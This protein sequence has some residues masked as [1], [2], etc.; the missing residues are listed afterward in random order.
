MMPIAQLAISGYGSLI[1]REVARATTRETLELNIPA[2]LAKR[3]FCLLRNSMI[4]VAGC[5]LSFAIYHLISKDSESI[6]S[7][8][9]YSLVIMARVYMT[10]AFAYFLGLRQ[11]GIDKLVML[12]CSVSSLIFVY[13]SANVFSGLIYIVI[14]YAL[15]N[16]FCT[17]IVA[18]LFKKIKIVESNKILPTNTI[19]TKEIFKM[20]AINF[21]GFLTLNTD[22]YIAKAYL[23]KI[24][25]LEF[26]IV[27][28]AMLGFIS[29]SSI[30][31]AIQTS[32]YA[33][34]Y[35]MKNIED[36]IKQVKLTASIISTFVIAAGFIFIV[37]YDILVREIISQQH[38][39]SILFLA[40]WLIFVLVVVNIM[41]IGLAIISIGDSDLVKVA[42]PVAVL[43]L[44]GAVIGAS[45]QGAIGMI[46]AMTL[47][48]MLSLAMHI[49]LFRKILNK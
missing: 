36:L 35:A 11:Y 47:C 2:P 49:K 37:A 6:S 9:I 38:T 46:F 48:G 12:L 26:G 45:I 25:F 14:A 22:L 42:F 13:I 28:K 43:G 29:A 23:D 1:T 40:L 15:P 34:S 39:F 17:A 3:T 30:I 16:I 33:S 8:I 32:S 27:S 44:I 41:N 5:I 18:Y 19:K 20:Y 21:A 10:W 7:I 31:I 4:F 24:S